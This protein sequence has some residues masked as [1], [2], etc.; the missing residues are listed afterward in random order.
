M[1]DIRIDDSWYYKPPGI[2]ERVSAGGIVVRFE[3]GRP[4]I[5]LAHEGKFRSY[6]LPK[7]GVEAGEDLETA[8]RREIME[9]AGLGDLQLL[10]YL[11]QRPRLDFEKRRW[12]TIHYFLFSTRQTGS[13]PGDVKHPQRCEW[14]APEDLPPLFWP[15]QQRL[16]AETLPLIRQLNPPDD[17]APGSGSSGGAKAGAPPLRFWW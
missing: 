5:A 1:D 8:A 12:M 9:E 6:V 3:A 15:E 7:G 17:T 16:L 14:F 2:R 13:Q 11:G 4:L 10:R